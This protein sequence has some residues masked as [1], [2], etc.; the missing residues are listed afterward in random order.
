[1]EFY[2][3]SHQKVE[4]RTRR[5]VYKASDETSVRY[6]YRKKPKNEILH[7]RMNNEMKKWQDFGFQL[8]QSQDGSPTL[9]PYPVGQSMHHVGGALSESIFIY[10]KAVEVFLEHHFHHI[11]QL[12]FLI[13]GLGLG[14]IELLILKRLILQNIAVTEMRM[15]SHEV[16]M[17]LVQQLQSFLFCSSPTPLAEQEDEVTQTYRQ[18]LTLLCQTD[19]SG[20]PL[21]QDQSVILQQTIRKLAKQLMETGQWKIE[22]ALNIESISQFRNAANP[23]HLVF[24]DAYSE[25]ASPEL[26]SEEFLD[27]FIQQLCDT[28]CVFSTYACTGRL[29]RALAKNNF[30]SLRREGFLGKRHST[31]MLKT[32]PFF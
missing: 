21:E 25:K 5:W 32:S 10:D 3:P 13:V 28:P 8:I 26:W 24:F 6:L 1:M 15:V 20:N 17:H 31:L 12:Q 4:N 2:K 16:N 30:K 18:M 9:R 19:L 29:K 22:G 14:Y 11:H 27:Q 23:F 7:H